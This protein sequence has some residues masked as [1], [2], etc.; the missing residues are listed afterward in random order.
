MGE[1]HPFHIHQNDFV[2]TE[3]NGLTTDEITAYPTNQLSDTVLL[4]AAYVDG[5]QTADNPYGQ[6]AAVQTSE[7]SLFNENPDAF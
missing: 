1:A 6:A 3:I 5:T 7:A 2:V 4:G